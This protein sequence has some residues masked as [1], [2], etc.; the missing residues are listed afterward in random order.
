[1]GY[2]KSPLDTARKKQKERKT[3]FKKLEEDLKKGS[4]RIQQTKIYRIEKN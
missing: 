4:I 1:M 2:A 3:A